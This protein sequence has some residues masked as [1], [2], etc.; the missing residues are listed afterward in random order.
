[1]T[2]GVG[3]PGQNDGPEEAITGFTGGHPLILD[4]PPGS[5]ELQTFTIVQK[6]LLFTLLIR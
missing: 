5:L 4:E 6:N 3:I 2:R 1:M